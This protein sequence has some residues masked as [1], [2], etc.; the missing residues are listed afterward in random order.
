MDRKMLVSESE[1][2]L[3]CISMMLLHVLV[4]VGNAGE[5][6]ST[7]S[8]VGSALMGLLVVDESSF[9]A[10]RVVASWTNMLLPSCL[11]GLVG[12][13]PVVA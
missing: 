3:Q 5:C 9:A 2:C 12:A 8:T 7:V 13:S 11:P 10:I 4:Q 1:V 6:V